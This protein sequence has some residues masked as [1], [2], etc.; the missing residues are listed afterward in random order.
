[1]F[2]LDQKNIVV[3][4]I[5][6][7]EGYMTAKI[8]K[9]VGNSGAYRHILEVI[10][11]T[12]DKADDFRIVQYFIPTEGW[13]VLKD[14]IKSGF[15]GIDKMGLATIISVEIFDKDGEIISKGSDYRVEEFKSLYER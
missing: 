2:H 8:L 13:V 11:K 14:V 6:V 1:M 7:W 3:I 15:S 5:G 10:K 12:Y 4:G 9:D